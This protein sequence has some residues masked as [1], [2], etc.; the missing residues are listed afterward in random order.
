[1]KQHLSIF[2]AVLLL[3][4]VTMLSCS[5]QADKQNDTSPPPHEKVPVGLRFFEKDDQIDILVGDLLLATYRMADDL[6]KPVL[7]PVLS[8]S[9]M[10]VTRGYPLQPRPGESR[11]HPHHMG[12]FFTCDEVNG[13]KFWNN[14]KTS[15]QIR[16]IAVKQVASSGSAGTLRT[17][18]HW[19]A[20]DD[21]V[22]LEE[23][24]TMTFRLE[25]Q[26]YVIDFV[27][28]LTAVNET[29]RIEDNKEAFFAI[30]VASWLREKGGDGEYLNSRGAIGADQVWGRRAR[31]VRL[32]GQKDDT[33]VGVAIF[34][35]P[36]SVN[37]PTHWHAR[38]YGL[39]AAN[40]V[41]Q[42]VFDKARK[43]DNPQPL[44]LTLEKG[45]TAHFGFRLMVYEGAHSQ[46]NLDKIYKNYVDAGASLLQDR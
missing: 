26:A 8:P 42:L 15:P 33:T 9:G 20:K 3:I 39:F 35:H 32:Q 5:L 21:T 30:R 31:W 18:S 43:R 45:E 14:T 6:P 38:N 16:H 44:N 22:L 10:E 4:F 34:N 36:A 11:D 2:A 1:M 37:F 17:L 29:I 23:D 7:Y 40:P 27:F 24:R 13:Q 28:R 41:G 46:E 12:V 19:I 25:K